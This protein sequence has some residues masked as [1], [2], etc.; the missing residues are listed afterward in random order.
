MEWIWSYHVDTKCAL[1]V[2]D[3]F[4]FLARSKN[5]CSNN[6]VPCPGNVIII[7][8]IQRGKWGGKG[9]VSPPTWSAVPRPVIH[10]PARRS[11]YVTAVYGLHCDSYRQ[12]NYYNELY[13]P[14]GWDE[15][16]NLKC[17]ISLVAWMID[18]WRAVTNCIRLLFSAIFFCICS[19]KTFH[20]HEHHATEANW[21]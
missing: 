13:M 10:L 12:Q 2:Y 3:A 20:R 18:K 5:Q 4:L 15:C 14:P 9:T 19:D 6:T 11:S 8:R 1:A 21:G 17:Q 16:S 7:L